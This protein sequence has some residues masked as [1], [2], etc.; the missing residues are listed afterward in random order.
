MARKCLHLLGIQVVLVDRFD[1]PVEAS[2]WVYLVRLQGH[3]R[4]ACPALST[5]PPWIDDAVHPFAEFQN[6]EFL[7]RIEVGIQK[8]WLLKPI[9]V[10]LNVAPAPTA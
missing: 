4:V 10:P 2:L 8:F 1:L 3:F 6:A 5:P 9:I 7:F